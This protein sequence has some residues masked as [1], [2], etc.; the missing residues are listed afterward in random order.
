L[1]TNDNQSY[2]GHVPVDY[3]YGYEFELENDYDAVIIED[4]SVI[5]DQVKYDEVQGWYIP[6][7]RSLSL[8]PDKFDAFENDV[9][10]AWCQSSTQIPPGNGTD[11][12]TPGEPN[13]AC[14]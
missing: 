6:K 13:D 2:N 8:N 10:E 11:K 12:G 9:L 7:G 3:E 1:G 4:G 14:E 5:V